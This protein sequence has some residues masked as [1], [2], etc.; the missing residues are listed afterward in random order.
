VPRRREDVLTSIARRKPTV[1]QGQNSAMPPMAKLVQFEATRMRT[2][3]GVL[4]WIGAGL[5]FVLGNALDRLLGRDSSE[6]RAERLRGVFERRGP[7]FVRIGQQLALHADLLPLAYC[8][9]LT[10]I[11]DDTPPMDLDEAT[12]RIEAALGR[13]VTEVFAMF[14]PEPIASSS[15]SCIYQA[16]MPNGDQVAI[17]V[18][19][20][21]IG[22]RLAADLAA[23]S[24]LLEAAEGFALIRLGRTRSLRDGMRLALFESLNFIFEARA[25]EIF[26]SRARKKQQDHIQAPKVYFALSNEE[27]LV[28]EFVSGVFLWEI[29]DALERNDEAALAD[30][31][32]KGIDFKV[33]AQHLTR[34]FYWE[35][36]E[37]MFFHADPHPTKIVA[38]PNNS[39]V[40][41][42]FSSCG[43]FSG[44][45]QRCYQE[46]Q[47]SIANE[48]ISGMV[49]ATVS[50]LEPLPPIDIDR[51]TKDVES[52]YWNWLYATK[53]HNAAWWE[54]STGELW[55]RLVDTARRYGIPIQMETLRMFRA[56]YLYDGMAMQLWSAIELDREY[57]AYTKERGRRSRRR[58]KRALRRRLERGLRN[59]DYLGIQGATRLATQIVNRAQH[60]L[61]APLP[62]YAEMI[63]KAA[64]G[65]SMV[66]K[67][68]V[69][70]AVLHL[71]AVLGISLFSRWVG[72][73]M[74]LA[75]ALRQLVAH[76]VYRVSIALLLLLV[77]RRALMRLEDVDVN[78][79]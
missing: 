68:V 63:G 17:K 11:R 70:G 53:S 59:V 65:V 2:L 41:V 1:R 52:L 16:L 23:L 74:S 62:R 48:D 73:S 9:A 42:D 45:V 36:L 72:L 66:L 20:S 8:E 15:A 32:A 43:R 46:L 12:K 61:D 26:A 4:K 47:A 7:S 77:V 28:T 25:A 55:M 75:A 57:R 19:R 29:L 3:I 31:S 24:W 64:F 35:A 27:V 34:S 6:R 21:S 38:R 49:E 14:D 60:V 44:R 79:G 30:I 69:I 5:T 37:N 58:V 56:T 71:L 78:K 40:F 33:L 76:P 39:L 50:M 67:I 18:R 13:P 22:A 54:R 10:D 51:F